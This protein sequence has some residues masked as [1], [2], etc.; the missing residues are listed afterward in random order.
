MW[1]AALNGCWSNFVYLL[2]FPLRVLELQLGQKRLK[3]TVDNTHLLCLTH[4]HKQTLVLHPTGWVITTGHHLLSL[5][6]CSPMPQWLLVIL[7]T[8][9]FYNFKI[10]AAL[11]SNNHV[12]INTFLHYNSL[13]CFFSVCQQLLQITICVCVFVRLNCWHTTHISRRSSKETLARH[14]IHAAQMHHHCILFRIFFF[15]L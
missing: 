8:L 14:S 11:F 6:H 7:I 13:L 3:T 12:W 4:T 2:F 10:L 1:W 9:L 5:P 15:Y